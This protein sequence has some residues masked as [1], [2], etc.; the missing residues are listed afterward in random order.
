M[1]GLFD[2]EF[3]TNSEV[4]M[5]ESQHNY[6]IGDLAAPRTVKLSFRYV[7][8]KGGLGLAALGFLW[9]TWSSLVFLG[10]KE[11]KEDLHQ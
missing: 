5:E 6:S 9:G 10:S 4:Q 2:Q 1:H 7:M 11:D 8:D 3:R